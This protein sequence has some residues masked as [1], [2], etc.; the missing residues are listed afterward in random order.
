MPDEVVLAYADVGNEGQYAPWWYADNADNEIDE[1]R[2]H[3]DE[4]AGSLRRQ[5]DAYLG[6]LFPGA[7]ATADEI[8]RTS[9]VRLRL[10]VGTT[11]DW[12]RPINIG[13]GLI[14]A[15]PILIALLLARKNQ[16]VVIDSPEAH[17]HPGAQSRMGETLSR[18]ARA[19]VQVFVETHS[20]HLLNGVRL[21]VKRKAISPSEVSVHFFGGVNESGAHG[22]TSLQMDSEGNIDAWPKGFF[23]QAERDL[24]ELTSWG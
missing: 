23:D 5:L 11:S 19:G 6:H 13:Y 2:R 1:A 20:D 16:I 24:G 18:F 22:V 3:P 7:Q 12:H 4:T 14:Y 21:A 17:L 10:R 9:F 8:A 15:F